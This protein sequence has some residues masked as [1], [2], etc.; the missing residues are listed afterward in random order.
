MIFPIEMPIY[1]GHFPSMFSSRGCVGHHWHVGLWACRPGVYRNGVTKHGQWK[2]PETWNFN[3]KIVELDAVFLRRFS[4]D[5][6]KEIVQYLKRLRTAF[7][8]YLIYVAVFGASHIRGTWNCIFSQGS[9]YQMF[10][11]VVECILLWLTMEGPQTNSF[12]CKKHQK[13]LLFWMILL[14]HFKTPA[15]PYY[16]PKWPTRHF[17]RFQWQA[18]CALIPQLRYCPARLVS[19]MRFKLALTN[20]GRLMVHSKTG[21]FSTTGRPGKKGWN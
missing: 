16:H 11:F 5:C 8:I 6:R 14:L 20:P 12:L 10:G 1:F 7:V 9:N 2:I 4:C 15:T 21:K 3:G 18:D 13:P 17:C 19:W